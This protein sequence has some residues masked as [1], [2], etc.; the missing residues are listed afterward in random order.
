MINIRELDLDARIQWHFLHWLLTDKT[1]NPG[2]D[3][4]LVKAAVARC[5]SMLELLMRGKQSSDNAARARRV[6]RNAWRAASKANRAAKKASLEPE[7]RGMAA[8]WSVVWELEAAANASCAAANAAW[9]L[10]C[11]P[12]KRAAIIEDSAI[13]AALS[14]VRAAQGNAWIEASKHMADK[15][16]ELNCEGSARRSPQ[17]PR[18]P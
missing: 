13:Y 17:E 10:H 3:H 7:K 14:M 9:S 18:Q 5:A 16:V 12:E 1:I 4:P 2:I 15:I 8:A 11:A 6:E